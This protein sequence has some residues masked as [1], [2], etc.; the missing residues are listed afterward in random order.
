M[1]DNRSDHDLSA[2]VLAS[3][4]HLLPRDGATVLVAVSGGADSVV[5]WDILARAQRWTVV[6]YHLDHALRD[7]SAVDAAFVL[8][9]AQDFAAAGI[10]TRALCERVEIARLA[11][12]WRCGLEAAGRRHRYARL[13]QIAGDVTAAAV[14]TAHHRDD[15]AETV[16]MNLL[17]GSGRSGHRG[18]P[19]L[20]RLGAVPLIRPLL[21]Y[22]RSRLRAYARERGLSWREDASNDDERF[23][24]NVVRR[25]VLP[26]L[27]AACPGTAEALIALSDAPE[28]IAGPAID[29][30]AGAIAI[31]R[32][33]QSPHERATVW[34]RMLIDLAIEP[35]RTRI[36]ELES[37]V[38]GVPGRA[39]RLGTWRFQR[40]RE[41]I[42]WLQASPTVCSDEV[43][44]PEPGIYRRGGQELT[45]R[46]APSPADARTPSGEAWL[47]ADRVALPLVWRLAGAT[48]RWRPLGSPGGRTVRKYLAD[49][50]VP[51]DA[52]AAV[53]VV[54]D[55]DGVVW[56]PGFGIAERA[57]VDPDA[58]RVLHGKIAG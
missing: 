13:E 21:P 7:A 16:L 8:A 32:L 26:V 55:R 12:D 23:R 48:E 53:A 39:Y 14:V 51:A 50:K 22:A 43:A 6:A 42:V 5:L 11:A 36:R 41:T 3:A 18:I 9:L 15:Q 17:R 25:R 46:P 38:G 49:R 56:I 27:E 52:R 33:P 24:R 40:T 1:P 20:R 58:P 28:I 37:L 44:I 57:R 29:A 19:A 34:R 45:I 35:G 2:N 30:A 54:A 4:A 31:A 47:S 10:A